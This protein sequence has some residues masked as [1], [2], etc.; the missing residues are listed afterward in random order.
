MTTAVE[1]FFAAASGQAP[2]L[3]RV[4]GTLRFDLREGAQVESWL[5]TIDKGDVSARRAEKPADC[6]VGAPRRLFEQLA[7]GRRNAL[8]ALLRNEL[9][10]AGK[11]ELLILFQRLFPGPPEARGPRRS[12]PAA[13]SR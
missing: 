8:T 9:T 6:V 3:R 12:R 1:R 4:S 7:S 2:S 13:T 11:L 5:V 10:A